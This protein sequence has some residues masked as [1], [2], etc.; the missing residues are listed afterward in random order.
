MSALAAV[1]QRFQQA[2][3]GGDA[4]HA[5]AHPG[6]VSGHPEI[7]LNAYRG[8]LANV[9][10]ANYP[11]LCRAMGDEAFRALADSYIDTHPS[12]FRSVRWYGDRLVDFIAG[13]A[14]AVPHPALVDIARLDWATCV[15]FD[16]ADADP[17]S[18]AELAQLA[19]ELWPTLRFTM[20][21]SFRLLRVEWAIEALWHALG[22]DE[23]AETEAPDARPHSL[24]V[25]RRGLD[26]RWR[27]LDTG[28]ATALALILAAGSFAECC[29]A[30][31]E[32]GDDDP[33]V[34]AATLLQ[35]WLAEGLIASASPAGPAS[36][37][38]S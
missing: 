12:K 29:A 25:W 1:Q 35:Q 9:L 8:R 7:Y 3:I 37:R 30:L 11:V 15:A 28:E 27:A 19:P 22:A 36:P 32:Q 24:I 5:A 23:S 14:A 21:P 2:V 33:A 20:V 18:H 38:G 26:T 10:A 31:A 34:T 17:L 13:D 4:C 6:E 16:A